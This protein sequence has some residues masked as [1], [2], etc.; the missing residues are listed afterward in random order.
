MS[1]DEYIKIFREAS[2]ALVQSLEKNGIDLKNDDVL[3]NYE[4]I[5]ESLYKCVVND[6]IEIKLSSATTP[7]HPLPKYGFYYKDYLKNSFISVK[8]EQYENSK[9]A[10]ILF[11]TQKKPFDTI[12][13][14]L[15][16]A[17]GKVAQE[18]IEVPYS[19]CKF[20]VE[21]FL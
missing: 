2:L 14:N 10:L 18:G 15:I 12:Y 3:E 9:L 13:C 11:K 19:S 5:F 21:Q 4:S 20:I 8:T 6:E 16:D 17:E 1:V 7:L